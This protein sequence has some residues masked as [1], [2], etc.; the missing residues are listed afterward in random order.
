M[1]KFLFSLFFLFFV[2]SCSFGNRGP[3]I[4]ENYT[5]VYSNIVDGVNNDNKYYYT[6]YYYLNPNMLPSIYYLVGWEYDNNTNKSSYKLNFYYNGT[7]LLFFNKLVLN[8]GESFKTNKIKGAIVYSGSIDLSLDLIDRF[9]KTGLVGK[10]YYD[11]PI[12]NG[13]SWDYLYNISQS[14]N[15]PAF[16]FEAIY[17]KVNNK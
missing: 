8:T 6:N 13:L 4:L 5:N 14:V 17:N 11:A 9:R 3:Y 1:N 16:V 12:K 15:I 7:G 10:I 2:V